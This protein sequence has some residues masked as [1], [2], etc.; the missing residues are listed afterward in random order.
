M[1]VIWAT[2]RKPG[3]TQNIAGYYQ[4]FFHGKRSFST[5]NSIY[6]QPIVDIINWKI[7]K[8]ANR[9]CTNYPK[10]TLQAG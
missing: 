10:P 6:P 9:G 1:L 5:G 2:L 8:K 4:G 3:F 7:R